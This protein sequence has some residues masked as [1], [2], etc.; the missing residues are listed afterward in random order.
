MK[1]RGACQWLRP[2]HDII[3]TMSKFT[4][5]DLIDLEPER[6]NALDLRC[7]CSRKGLSKEIYSTDINRPGMA[8]TGFF[9]KFVG[10]RIQLVGRGEYSYLETAP[11][12]ILMVQLEKLLKYNIPCFIFCSDLEPPEFFRNAAEDAGADEIVGF[13][14]LALLK[15]VHEYFLNFHCLACR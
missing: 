15:R 9:E 13:E 4:I 11:L 5:L 6:P 10:E 8:L 14:Y 2:L 3:F 7:V 1:V 12:D